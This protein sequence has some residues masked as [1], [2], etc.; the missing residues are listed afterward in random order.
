MLHDLGYECA[1]RDRVFS[2]LLVVCRPRN[3]RLCGIER[4]QSL[5]ASHEVEGMLVA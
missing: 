4:V 2:Q 5:E 3:G 1:A